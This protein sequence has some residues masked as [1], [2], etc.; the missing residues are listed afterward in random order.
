MEDNTILNA[1]DNGRLRRRKI[2]HAQIHVDR[3]ARC[4]CIFGGI[5]PGNLLPFGPYFADL[6]QNGLDSVRPRQHSSVIS[7]H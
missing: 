6:L 1:V 4:F 2:G 3:R 7:N 5:K